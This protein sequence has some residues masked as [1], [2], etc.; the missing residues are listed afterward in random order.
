MK[1]ELQK[2]SRSV[3]LAIILATVASAFVLRLFYL[4][5][6]QHDHY[7]NLADSE[8]VT[9]LKIPATRGLIYGLNGDTPVKLVMNE[10]VYTVFADPMMVDDP[11]SVA[12]VMKE[13]AGGNVK[14]DFEKLL[15]IEG[16]RYQVIA[17]NI[18]RLQ[19]DKIKEEK[20]HG[21]GFQAVSQRV[22]PEGS[23][24]SQVLGFVNVEGVGNYGIE[25]A[26]NQELMGEDGRLES[27]TDIADVPL[28]IG[29]KNI[30][31]PAKDG[32]NIVLSIDRNIQAKAEQ[33]LGDGLKRTGAKQGSI[34]VMNPNNGQV[35]AMA[36][37]PTYDQ[38]KYYEVSDLNLFNNPIISKPYEP[39]SVIKPFTMATAIDKGVAKPSDTYR[40]EGRIRVDD[41]WIA[42][43]Y[44]GQRGTI[45]FQTM[46][47]WSLNTGTV[48]LL[49]RLG[50]GKSITKSA[51]ET[52]YDYFYN[53]FRLGQRTGIALS[54]EAA[55]EIVS[56]DRVEG[57]AV[58]YSNMSF[59]QGMNT[60][61]IQV[62]AGFSSII[63]GGEYYSPTIIA[64]EVKD[65]QFI[66]NDTGELLGKTVSSSTSSAM[67]KMLVD[68]RQE[69]Y[70]IYDRKGYNIGGKTGTSE[71]IKNGAYTD[72]QTI[73]SYIGFGGGEKPEYVV[74]I[75]LSGEDQNLQG[76]RD[77]VPIF[78]DISNW[79][80]GYLGVQP[81]G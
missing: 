27:V 25:G 11:E 12:K 54:G 40:N 17:T 76:A 18:T 78:N 4:Q 79:L 68:A 39:A 67:R 72:K 21:I 35:M 48:T 29:N 5:V 80:L 19:A 81:K 71:T 43:A 22:Y 53:K 8:Q 56:P 37:L 32:K 15:S 74:M 36:N 50:D 77:A 44:Q 52:L 61:A 73:G 10:T 9:R 26:L 28:T 7:S 13:V 55:G 38:S 57:N 30:R 41:R 23:L 24:A 2:G 33:A 75:V 31:I 46:M 16:S 59:G 49:Q 58:R 65:G 63:N 42:N 64:G 47:N 3:V 45:T 51:R 34:L 6:I 60:T 70:S 20:L 62:A 14:K 1:L 66:K 69:F